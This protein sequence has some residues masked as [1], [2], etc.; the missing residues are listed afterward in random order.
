MG[1]VNE[2]R[3]GESFVR[4]NFGDAFNNELKCSVRGYVDVPV[5]DFKPSYLHLHPHVEVPGASP[6]QYNQ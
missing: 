3:E 6:I 5:G 2:Q 4:K 1:R